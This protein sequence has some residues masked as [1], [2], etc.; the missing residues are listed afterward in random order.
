MK[1]KNAKTTL[2]IVHHMNE[3]DCS[4]GTIQLAQSEGWSTLS[5]R[6]RDS[7]EHNSEKAI[8]E[9]IEGM[10]ERFPT[11]WGLFRRALFHASSIPEFIYSNVGVDDILTHLEAHSSADEGLHIYDV[12]LEV[13]RKKIEDGNTH[14]IELSR[15]KKTRLAHLIPSILETRASELKQLAD[16]TATSSDLIKTYYGYICVTSAIRGKGLL[17]TLE[18]FLQQNS[19]RLHDECSL[20]EPDFAQEDFTS[21]NMSSNEATLLKLG[22]DLTSTNSNT[23]MIAARKMGKIG[24]PRTEPFLRRSTQDAYSWVRKE[25]VRALAKLCIPESA[26]VLDACL[27]DFNEDIRNIAI[28]GLIEIGSPA[29]Q[30]L[31]NRIKADMNFDYE[32]AVSS[33]DV[34]HPRSLDSF[35]AAVKYQKENALLSAIRV[36]GH[37]ADSSD[38]ILLE[39]L[40]RNQ[41]EK[42][43]SASKNAIRL[44]QERTNNDSHSS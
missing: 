35:I 40:S 41:N 43:S 44:I 19:I 42:I 3:S 27:E 15:L 8:A 28:S 22:L 5:N 32:S 4:S 13:M 25:S 6:I 33:L 20:I 11:N 38:L 2:R 24:D 16:E 18:S 30:Q 21:R 9:S 34:A 12:A 31:I 1:V 39:K 23:R 7:I 37:I 26:D 10:Q 14:F 17:R 36:M 29:K